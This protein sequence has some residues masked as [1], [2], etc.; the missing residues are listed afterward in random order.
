MIVGPK[1]QDEE[2][3]VPL[4]FLRKKGARV[5][6]VSEDKGEV[7]GLHGERI[8]ANLTLDDVDIG[9]YDAMVIPGGRSPA[10]LREN[11]SAVDLVKDFFKTGKPVA[12]ICH[13]PQMLAAAGLLD[14]VRITGYP[15]IADEMKQAGA[16]FVDEPVVKTDNLITSRDPGDLDDF[17]AALE[18]ALS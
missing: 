12:A 5:D 15:K 1:F 6:V 13:G 17:D 11:H 3:R 2:A 8:K 4:D 10:H 18:E 7:E 16:D 14:G 9:D